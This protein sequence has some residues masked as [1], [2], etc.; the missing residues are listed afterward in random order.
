MKN[1]LPWSTPKGVCFPFS[2][3][4]HDLSASL[5]SF[6]KVSSQLTSKRLEILFQFMLIRPLDF[7]G[8]RTSSKR[9]GLIGH[10]QDAFAMQKGRTEK[11]LVSFCGAEASFSIFG[12]DVSI[13]LF[14]G[15]LVSFITSC[16]RSRESVKALP[17]DATEA[18][19][20]KL[21]LRTAEL[22]QAA[23]VAFEGSLNQVEALRETR[24][25]MGRKKQVSAFFC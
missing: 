4:Q 21:Y 15:Y 13:D 9:Q 17:R 24:D 12:S 2:E 14:F 20:Q 5:Q 18:M 1:I 7:S 10:L 6:R 16:L 11:A 22:I 19:S 3:N 8:P 23:D 25:I